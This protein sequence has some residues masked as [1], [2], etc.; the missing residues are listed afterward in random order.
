MLK[1]SPEVQ[2]ARG[3]Y[4]KLPIPP[5]DLQHS[6]S[7]FILDCATHPVIPCDKISAQHLAL[8]SCSTFILDCATHP[9]PH[10]IKY[11][12]RIRAYQFCAERRNE[13]WLLSKEAQSR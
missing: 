10:A 11:L 8:S 5:N 1:T 2:V 4:L 3:G 7:T 9:S 12:L 13:G 6:C